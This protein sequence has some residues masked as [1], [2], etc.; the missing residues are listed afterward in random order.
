MRCS[1]LLVVMVI[2][3]EF[4]IGGKQS[5]QRSITNG[6]KLEVVKVQRLS[7][8]KLQIRVKLVN[9]SEV[10]IFVEE[11]GR[12]EPWILQSVS[13]YKRVQGR[14]WIFAGPTSDIPPVSVVR[15]GP[16]QELQSTVGLGDPFVRKLPSEESIPMHGKFRAQIRYF[17]SE[18]DWQVFMSQIRAS[19][20]PSPQAQIVQ[21]LVVVSSSFL[22]PTVENKQ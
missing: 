14:G 16:N 22:I 7:A 1:V 2:F 20:H 17:S 10:P 13:I 21:P 5:D 6:V 19:S 3:A 15:V 18:R 4:A 12:G 9:G 11:S 8:D